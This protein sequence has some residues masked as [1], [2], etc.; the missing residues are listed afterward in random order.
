M[1]TAIPKHWMEIGD[2]YERMLGPKAME[3]PLEDQDC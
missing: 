3:T 1:Q 2:P